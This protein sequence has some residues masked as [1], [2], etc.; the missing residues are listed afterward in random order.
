MGD[1]KMTGSGLLEI[2]DYGKKI[3][4]YLWGQMSTEREGGV[5]IL[6]DD[7][8]FTVYRDR[9]GASFKMDEER[10]RESYELLKERLG[11]YGIE[12]PLRIPVFT[13]NIC[14]LKAVL[15]AL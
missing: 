10:N 9:Y 1:E 14:H 15:D 11:K 6:G 5:G 7:A 13:F 8:R 2:S 4:C 3:D 12:P